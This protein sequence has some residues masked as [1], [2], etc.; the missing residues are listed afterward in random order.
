M[1][2]VLLP[3]SDNGYILAGSVGPEF[4]PAENVYI[5]KLDADGN[6]EWGYHYN[7]FYLP[8]NG[9]YHMV[10]VDDGYVFIAKKIDLDEIWLVKLNKDGLVETSSPSA[11]DFNAN[12]ISVF[13]NP[14]SK[15][16][17]IQ[18]P[19]PKSGRIQIS[20]LQGKIIERQNISDKNNVEILVANLSSGIY[21][22]SFMDEK[23]N[24]IVNKKFI[25]F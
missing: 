5:I 1:S 11:G 13:P 22:F 19:E 3:T 9:A 16:L 21:F 12:F 24:K 7:P 15:F 17:N 4:D 6:W 18:F 14:A 25:K 8:Y 2:R 23:S 10:E 20:N